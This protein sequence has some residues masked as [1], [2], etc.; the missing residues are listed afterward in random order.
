MYLIDHSV[1]LLP[2]AE[3]EVSTPF[4]TGKLKAKYLENPMYDLVLG[5]V[6][7]VRSAEDPDSTWNGNSEE[8]SMSNGENP[9]L[10]KPE[11][12]TQ[13][14]KPKPRVT[15]ER[16]DPGPDTEDQISASTVSAA[17]TE[18]QACEAGKAFRKLKVPSVSGN[19]NVKNI[20]QDQQG[21]TTLARCFREVGNAYE[22]TKKLKGTWGCVVI[23]DKLYRKHVP[24]CGVETL[25][26]VV[27]E[28]HRAA[29]LE[30]A[31]S[32]MMAG[33]LGSEKC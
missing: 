24:P 15:E 21:D 8:A 26:L 30:V 3:I 23:A 2:E 4:F 13:T 16:E 17:L 27:P 12:E 20:S 25:Q 11:N 29:V 32:G 5:N 1:H 28:K 6:D 9:E 31:H 7:G 10:A 19:N 14:S 22:Q 33:H 18:M